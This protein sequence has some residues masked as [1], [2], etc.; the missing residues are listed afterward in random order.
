MAKPFHLQPLVYLAKE[1]SQAAAQRL[2]KLKQVWLE[3]ENKHSQLQ[4]YLA[5]YRARL[6]QQTQAGLSAL[7]WRDYQAFIHKLE[8]AIQA[9]A[10]EIERCQHAW[11]RGQTEWQAQERE[12]NA[13]Q[14]LRKR[15]DE[16][17]RKVDAKQ[18]QRQQDEFARNQYHRKN[19]PHE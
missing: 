10:Q 5:E 4:N 3:A 15:H 17:E 16:V 8:M 6:H 12:V 14:T 18:D 2:A 11:E 19:N 9:Q 7:Q 13:Y 1:R